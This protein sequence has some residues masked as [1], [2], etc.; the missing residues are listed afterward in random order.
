M[1][2]AVKFIHKGRNDW[3]YCIENGAIKMFDTKN[4]AEA[5]AAKTSDLVQCLGLDH[6]YKVVEC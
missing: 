3:T 4:E 5:F 6:V 2:Y 1:K